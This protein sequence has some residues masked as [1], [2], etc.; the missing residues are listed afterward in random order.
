MYPTR[1][2]DV[3]RMI[4]ERVIQTM[5]DTQPSRLV[6]LATQVPLLTVF[7]LAACSHLQD[8]D[9]PK[10]MLY[11]D[12]RDVH[13]PPWE[14]L[15]AR[16]A[17][18]RNSL[19]PACGSTIRINRERVERGPYAGR[20]IPHD[21]RIHTP[22][23]SAIPRKDFGT[24]TRWYQEDGNTQVFRMFPGDDNI[25][26]PRAMA[27]RSEA[28]GGARWK[29]G[30]GWHEWSGRY[31]FIKVRSGAVFQIK[32]NRTYWSIQLVLQG[33]DDG[34]YDLAYQKLHDRDAKQVLAQD[35]VGRAV[36]IRVLDDGT[37]HRVYVNGQLRVDG[38]FTDRKDNETNHPRW[39]I[40]S[41]RSAMDRE[42]LILVTG[43]YVGKPR[44]AV[45]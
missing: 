11:T 30:D 36:D 42:I 14:E 9:D 16:L 15:K 33:N 12:L 21:I 35:V 37:R 19:G 41:P 28:F 2:D 17:I 1:S 44:E 3:L 31:T 18:G 4:G 10:G 45:E 22:T 32:H 7:V 34:T 8:P 43:V 6:S 38:E 26:N 23:H 24:M 25:R 39:G 29:R 5:D 40:Y 27:P 13:N 20:R